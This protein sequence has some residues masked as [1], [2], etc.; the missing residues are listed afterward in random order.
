METL[1]I[2]RLSRRYH[3]GP[4]QRE[5]RDDLN[6]ASERAFGDP[7]DKALARQHLD[8]EEAI[9][10]RRV[11]VRL[12]YATGQSVQRTGDA[13]SEAI[14][15][16][17][18][19]A[20]TRYG[21]H[22]SDYLVRYPSR[23]HGLV[24]FALEVSA[25]R[26]RHA[27][28]WNQLGWSQLPDPPTLGEASQQ[29]VQALQDEPELLLPV[30]IRLARAERLAPWLAS[31]PGADQ[32]ALVQRLLRQAGVDGYAAPSTP[33][34]SPPIDLASG[35]SSSAPL[36]HSRIARHLSALAGAQWPP[37]ALSTR[38]WALLCL[39]EREPALANR[40]G[41]VVAAQLADAERQLLVNG[42]TPE[43]PDG[44]PQRPMPGDGAAPEAPDG[45]PEPP[46]LRLR[47]APDSLSVPGEDAEA[48]P[49]WQRSD[50]TSPGHSPAPHTPA[51]PR[52]TDSPS[53]G[54]PQRLT[55]PAEDGARA[56][57]LEP[58][59]HHSDWGGLFYLL[60]LLDDPPDRTGVGVAR[61]LI[62][63]PLF[64]GRSL[65]W[66]F[67]HLFQR[68]FTQGS[69]PAV[70]ATDPSLRLLCH[71]PVDEETPV[72]DAPDA[73]E[74]DALDTQ[75]YR[76]TTALHQRLP[77]AARSDTPPW[78]WLCQRQ[79]RLQLDTAWLDVHFTLDRLDT[80]IR[81]AGLDLDPGYV[82]WLGKVVKLHYD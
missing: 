79:A 28:A 43:A 75:A 40:P 24:D 13:W 67:F 10:L 14:A 30:F 7:L 6:R 25:G 29:L 55:E 65:S 73:E 78:C 17:I 63:A 71:L 77:T 80:D 81:R 64:A 53:G 70:P 61:A 54:G 32:Q 5:L 22:H 21:G 56:P 9:C 37:L 52:R 34:A 11:S 72:F 38:Q 31:L 2:Q 60:A 69:E 45:H 68:L 82:P 23:L 27:W 39:L 33:L 49:P 58:R 62:E 4:D 18:Q 76:L 66:L 35:P 46:P 41:R 74:G 3:L 16:A 57:W 50:E 36:R 51:R 59:I 12:D 15:A 8:G 48:P 44:S 20:L 19:G 42:A 26:I 1:I 47:G